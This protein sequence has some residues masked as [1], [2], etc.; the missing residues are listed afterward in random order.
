MAGL[1]LLLRED[2]DILRA[3]LFLWERPRHSRIRHKSVI[4][5]RHATTFLS[6]PD[7]CCRQSCVVWRTPFSR[8][9]WLRIHHFIT[10]RDYLAGQHSPRNRQDSG[11]LFPVSLFGLGFTSR[12]LDGASLGSLRHRRTNLFL[13]Q[14]NTLSMALARLEKSK[15]HFY[16]RQTVYYRPRYSGASD[17]GTHGKT[18]V[19]QFAG[20]S[21]SS[22]K[23]AVG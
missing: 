22:D 6:A 23:P 7:I 16:V 13:R 11:H 9:A 14:K 3:C 21:G 12:H 1:R 4:R 10:Y 5:N 15:R 17:N 8:K 2:C 18:L 20:N 19:K